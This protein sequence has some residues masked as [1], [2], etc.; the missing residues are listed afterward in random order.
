M[1][2]KDNEHQVVARIKKRSWSVNVM[3]LEIMSKPKKTFSD[4][5]TGI[6][7]YSGFNFNKFYSDDEN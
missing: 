5:E 2:G 4:R 1:A 6:S 3:T 7:E